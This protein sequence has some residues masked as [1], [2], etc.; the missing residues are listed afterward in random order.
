[1]IDTENSSETETKTTETE[2]TTSIQK[3]K[4]PVKVPSPDTRLPVKT[5]QELLPY[6]KE[7]YS[8]IEKA[9][10]ELSEELAN[11][12]EL[13]DAIEHSFENK[14]ATDDK[15]QT[16]VTTYFNSLRKQFEE[17]NEKF[18]REIDYNRELELKVQ[19]NEYKGQIYLLER[20]LN[21][22]R[23]KITK[24]IDE[25]NQTVKDNML[26]VSDKVRELKSADTM[27]EEAIS[28]FRTDSMSASENE[29]K[30]LKANCESMLRTFT[31]NAQKTLETVKKTSIDFITQCEKENKS[32]IGKV[33][34]VKGKLTQES[35]IVIIFGCIG[36]ASL[37]INLF[38]R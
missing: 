14:T 27:I 25:I 12:S 34:V 6:E 13:R 16:E 23:A 1:M 36:I 37:I 17:F 35:W 21:E 3:G 24:T 8:T 7:N 22:E 11:I 30:A 38:I 5:K 32:L 33:P 19:N 18:T 4:L 31:E 9:I 29:Y 20:E 26:S 15:F 28:K 2:N 10:I